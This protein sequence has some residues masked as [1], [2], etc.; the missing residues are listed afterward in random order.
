MLEEIRVFAIRVGMPKQ[1]TQNYP[2]LFSDKGPTCYG[3]DTDDRAF[4]CYLMTN[5]ASRDFEQL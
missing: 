4:P 1:V 2:P 3:Y 5:I